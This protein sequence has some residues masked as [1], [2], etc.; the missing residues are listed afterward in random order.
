MSRQRP[1]K[2]FV[3]DK[4]QKKYSYVLTEPVGRNFD[5]RF[6]PDL[7]PKQMLALGV[8]GGVYMRDCTKEFPKDWFIKAKFQMKDT[9]EHN[10]KINCFR[11][12]ASQPLSV[13]QAKGWIHPQDPRGWFQWYCRYYMGRRSEDDERQIKRWGAM[14]R[15]IMQIKNNCRAGDIFCRSRQRQAVLHWAYDSRKI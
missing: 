6:K 2:V 15:H 7:S 8:F 10:P 1:I 5:P 11:V 13:W 4:M 12:N 14:R 3:N 9:Y